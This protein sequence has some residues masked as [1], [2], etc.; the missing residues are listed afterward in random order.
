MNRGLTGAKVLE[1]LGFTDPVQG[2]LV[3]VRKDPAVTVPR[4]AVNLCFVLPNGAGS[5]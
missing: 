5:R 1:N 2:R 4:H 3:P